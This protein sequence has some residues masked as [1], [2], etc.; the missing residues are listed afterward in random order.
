MVDTIFSSASKQYRRAE[1]MKESS[2]DTSKSKEER[3]YLKKQSKETGKRARA[4]EGK[5]KKFSKKLSKL[6][7]SKII[8]RRIL[9]KET[10]T[11]IIKHKEV[12]SVLG[13]PNRF[14]K[15]EMMKEFE[16]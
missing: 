3:D 4:I 15:N 2:K 7:R 1:F 6:A 12:E 8:S 5:Q 16:L 14:F 13:D 10:P 11:L 9:K